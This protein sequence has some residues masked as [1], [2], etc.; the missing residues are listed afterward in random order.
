MKKFAISLIALAALST[1]SFAE[2]SRDEDLRE[3]GIVKSGY[4]TPVNSTPTGVYAFATL[5]QSHGGTAYDV[6]RQN[7]AAAVLSTDNH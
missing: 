7:A 3:A 2:G 6:A 1:A 5:G 4:G